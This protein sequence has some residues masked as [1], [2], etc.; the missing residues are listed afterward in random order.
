MVKVLRNHGPKRHPVTELGLARSKQI[1]DTLEDFMFAPEA[2]SLV[3]KKRL[4]QMLIDNTE[5][6]RK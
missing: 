2:G 4:N 6:Y 5:L 1:Y 3:A